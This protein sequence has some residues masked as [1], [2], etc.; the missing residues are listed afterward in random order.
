MK[1]EDSRNVNGAGEN[2]CMYVSVALMKPTGDHR[3]HVSKFSDLTVPSLTQQLIVLC[4]LSCSCV[5][6]PFHNY[7]YALHTEYTAHTQTSTL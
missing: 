6:V 7:L 3:Q 5:P 1:V 2:L 4:L